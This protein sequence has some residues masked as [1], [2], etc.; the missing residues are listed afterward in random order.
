MAPTAALARA[1][2]V[3]RRIASAFRAVLPP[4]LLPL[5]PLTRLNSAYSAKQLVRIVVPL[6]LALIMDLPVG[7]VVTPPKFCLVDFMRRT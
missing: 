7:V 6:T 2:V 1:L 5:L 4:Q 3:K